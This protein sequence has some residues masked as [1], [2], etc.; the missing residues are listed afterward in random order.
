MITPLEAFFFGTLF[1]AVITLYI[2]FGY[3][4]LA[5]LRD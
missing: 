4:F 2:E 5:R 3:V 1:G